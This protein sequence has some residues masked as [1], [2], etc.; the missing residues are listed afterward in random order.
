MAR[1]VLSAHLSI[2]RTQLLFGW[3]QG[4]AAHTKGLSNRFD[5]CRGFK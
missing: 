5:S 1:N 2:L 3:P 4:E